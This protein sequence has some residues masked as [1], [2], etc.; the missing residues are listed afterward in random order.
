MR[1]ECRRKVFGVVLRR[2]F[3]TNMKEPKEGYDHFGLGL[4]TGASF[5]IS[6]KFQ[7]KAGYEWDVARYDVGSWPFPKTNNIY[8]N[9]AFFLN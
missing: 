3:T 6:N 9:I 7:I 4:R 2:Q 8:F 1:K 5:D